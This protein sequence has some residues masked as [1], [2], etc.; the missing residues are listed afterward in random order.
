M[1]TYCSVPGSLHQ[2]SSKIH[3]C[4]NACPKHPT[5]AYR[6]RYRYHWCDHLNGSKHSPPT[7]KA[8]ISYPPPQHHP[9]TFKPRKYLQTPETRTPGQH[10]APELCSSLLENCSKS[11]VFLVPLQKT[12]ADKK[13]KPHPFCCFYIAFILTPITWRTE[14]LN[15]ISA[16][17]HKVMQQREQA[18]RTFKGRHWRGSVLLS[19]PLC[20]KMSLGCVR[21]GVGRGALLL[22]NHKSCLLFL[23]LSKNIWKASLFYSLSI[24]TTTSLQNVTP[25]LK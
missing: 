7:L 20:S 22:Q 18:A 4:R 15:T 13:N 1:L 16:M 12:E 6:Y 21:C 8:L 25:A 10:P 19:F 2:S 5:Q 23:H 24:G 14:Q 3:P 9:N 11:P 17:W